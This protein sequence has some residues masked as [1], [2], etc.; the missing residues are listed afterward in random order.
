VDVMTNICGMTPSWVYGGVVTAGGVIKNN[1]IGGTMPEPQVRTGRDNAE[2][3]I[4]S[5]LL[6]TSRA[7]I[8]HGDDWPWMCNREWQE[9]VERCLKTRSTIFKDIAFSAAG[10]PDDWMFIAFRKG[11][12]L[13]IANRSLD[14]PEGI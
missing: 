10:R 1:S 12:L 3:F 5:V 2:T 6:D 9:Y 13:P 4:S 14:D 7:V 8:R 11:T